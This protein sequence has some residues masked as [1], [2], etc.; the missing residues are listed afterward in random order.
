MVN[1]YGMVTKD[2][3]FVFTFQMPL[4]Y[5]S[6]NGWGYRLSKESYA[7]RTAIQAS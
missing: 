2:E 6:C 1:H 3:Y 7:K 4:A 5:R